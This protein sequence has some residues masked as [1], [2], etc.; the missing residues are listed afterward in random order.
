MRSLLFMLTSGL[1]LCGCAGY[2]VGPVK[3]TQM[4]AIA[5][6]AVPNLRNTTLEPRLESMVANALVKQIQQDGTYRVTAESDSD[7]IV[8][9]TIKKLLRNPMRGSRTD[10]YQTS[11]YSLSLVAEIKVVERSTGAILLNRELTGKTTFLVSGSDLRTADVNA[12][13]RQ[14]IPRA[15]ADLATQAVSYLSEGW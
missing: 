2:H 7:A 6:L 8:Q 14:A 10:Y 5:R 3:P 15:A 11:E 1:L 9:G 13:E 4:A 12:D